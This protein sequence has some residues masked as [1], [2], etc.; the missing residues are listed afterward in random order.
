MS[1]YAADTSLLRRSVVIMLASVIMMH[2]CGCVND[3]NDLLLLI[4]SDTVAYQCSSHPLTLR[5]IAPSGSEGEECTVDVS[6]GTFTPNVHQ[7]SI[8]IQFDHMN[9]VFA[10]WYP[11]GN[12]NEVRFTAR[13]ADQA[14]VILCLPIRAVPTPSIAGLTEA[15]NAGELNVGRVILGPPWSRERIT[16]VCTEAQLIDY[17]T[18]PPTRGSTVSPTL[19]SAG[20][21]LL[22]IDVS[23]GATGRVTLQVGICDQPAYTSL[24][25]IQ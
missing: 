4:A 5:L 17:T 20:S 24:F 21:A 6:T 1:S 9:T 8:R 12:D 14:E 25:T 13:I 7:K 16:A 11:D 19:D 10:T 22:G 3:S 15:L 2:T 18:M 23:Q